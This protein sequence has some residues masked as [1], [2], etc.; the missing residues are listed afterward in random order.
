M[1]HVQI[2]RTNGLWY[3]AEYSTFS[4]SDEASNYTLTVAGYSGDA[5]DALLSPKYPSWRANGMMF[6]TRDRDN[7]IRPDANCV[8]SRGGW[9]L[10][11]CGTSRINY[12]TDADWTTGDP[13]FDVQASRMLLRP[14]SY[15]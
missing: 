2:H 11:Q 8:F 13:A 15:S 3:S 6:S 9:W 10:G 5:G 1:C 14:T 4:I 12:D 7:D